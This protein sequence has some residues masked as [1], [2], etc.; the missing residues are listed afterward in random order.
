[1]AVKPAHTAVDV[2][3]VL[4]AADGVDVRLECTRRRFG[5]LR[6]LISGFVSDDLW[7][8]SAWEA[9][10]VVFYRHGRFWDLIPCG[11]DHDV[12]QEVSVRA[13]AACQELTVPELA[14]RYGLRPSP[15]DR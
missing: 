9:C 6:C 2:V 15:R 7:E 8:A 4:A 11:A 12:A 10:N 13:H 1:M 3:Q 14:V 5:L